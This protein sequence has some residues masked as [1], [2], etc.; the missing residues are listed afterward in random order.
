MKIALLLAS[1]LLLQI[2]AFAAETLI[3]GDS[4]VVGAFGENLHHL[5]QSK[6]KEGVR[7]V[8]IAGG[9]ATTFTSTNPKQRTLS[10]GY[11]D[12]KNA[13][14]ILKK[15]GTPAT[16]PELKTLLRET[17][18]TR[19]IVEL[20]DNF[21][22]YKNPSKNS[23]A[24]VAQQVQLILKELL[25]EHSHV[26][27][28]WVTPTWTDKPNGGAYQKSNERLLQVIQLI[29]KAAEPRCKVIDSAQ[30]LGLTPQNL[31]TTNDGL[32]F[33]GTN[34]KK[35]ATA[36]AAKILELENHKEVAVKIAPIQKSSS[37]TR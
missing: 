24:M 31:R 23:D 18:P 36:A 30:G 2:P 4:H 20:G 25:P 21:A 17:R 32:H 14:E 15:G 13:N 26:T 5:I 9:S 11:A 7:T 27:C 10:F 19:L 6:T 29:K 33:D 28:Y 37:G 12:R 1:F 22:D 8:G 16:T 35:W 3:I 34:G